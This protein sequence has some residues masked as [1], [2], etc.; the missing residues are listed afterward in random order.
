MRWKPAVN[1]RFEITDDEWVW[2]A[3]FAARDDAAAGWALA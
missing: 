2:L 1:R 3:P